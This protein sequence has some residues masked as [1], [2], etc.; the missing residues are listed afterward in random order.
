VHPEN[1]ALDGNGDGQMRASPGL[2]LSLDE[3]LLLKDVTP[4]LYR[5]FIPK[6]ASDNA[7][8][9]LFEIWNMLQGE[10]FK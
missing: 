2:H 3:P 5:N 10:I 4:S 7:R 8:K 1:D 6:E 9:A